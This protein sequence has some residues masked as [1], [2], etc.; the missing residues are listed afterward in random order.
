MNITETQEN[1]Y[2]NIVSDI[3]ELAKNNGATAAE[4]LASMSTGIS[5]NVRNQEV[6]TIEFDRDKGLGITVYF[7]Q[8]KGSASTSDLSKESLSDTVA[9]ACKLAKLMSED[10][11]CGLADAKLMAY[12]YPMLDLMHPWGINAEEAIEL[13]IQCEKSGLDYSKDITNSEGASISTHLGLTV[14]GNS[15]GF[16]G[17]YKGSRHSVSCVLIA[18][19][20]D[21]MQRDY[22][23]S[24]SRLHDHLESLKTIGERAARRTIARLNPRK[25][26][27]QTAKILFA[28]EMARGILSSFISA[29]SG[30]SLYRESSF[31]LDKLGHKVFSDIITLTEDPFL[32]NGLGSAAFDSEGVRTKKKFIVENGMLQTYVLGSYSARRL[33]MQTTANAG[34]I[35]NLL[36]NPGQYNQEQLIKNMGT[37]LLVTELMG[38]GVN[39]VTGDYSRGA[40][41]FW[42]ENGEIQYPVEGVTIAGNLKDM[43]NNIVAVG[44]DIDQRSNIQTGSLLVDSMMVAGE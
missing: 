4:V 1:N 36:I 19:S 38:Q 35:H 40:S 42:I 20:Q 21:K 3:V 6:D 30:G 22:W 7:G 25:V 29:I 8:Q 12:G 2:K 10:E 27:T 43:L 15:H 37:G 44:N 28:P 5:V 13:A 23:Y 9:K 33:G 26:K 14:Y 16:I 39:I 41:G 17:S 24:V 11:Y 32:P 31:L 18:S 34:G